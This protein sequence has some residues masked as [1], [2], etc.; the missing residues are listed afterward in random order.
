MKSRILTLITAV[1]VMLSSAVPVMADSAENTKTFYSPKVTFNNNRK[2]YSFMERFPNDY[3]MKLSDTEKASGKYSLHA[4]TYRSGTDGGDTEQY[5]G[6][7]ADANYSM[8]SNMKKNTEYTFSVK[9]KLGESGKINS[10]RVYQTGQ[11]NALSEPYY[12]IKDMDNTPV[13]ESDPDG[14]RIYTKT[15]N[16]SVCDGGYFH[17]CLGSAENVY[18]DD[19]Y[20]KNNTDNE[21]LL[22]Y[23][24]EDCSVVD[25]YDP[26]AIEV[27]TPDYG[28][29]TI[30]W[31][32]PMNKNVG[33]KK[34]SKITT[35]GTETSGI[36]N[37]SLYDVSGEDDPEN[38]DL[39]DITPI[40][41]LDTGAADDTYAGVNT[42]PNKMSEC[43]LTGL[44]SDTEYK[45]RLVITTDKTDENAK[46][47]ENVS[48]TFIE[49]KTLKIPEGWKPA[50]ETLPNFHH[51]QTVGFLNNET[52]PSIAVAFYNPKSSNIKNITLERIDGDDITE[53]SG[54][55]FTKGNN[56]VNYCEING[57][58]KG[59][60]Y[61][62][63]LNCEFS[64]GTKRS[65]AF[66]G[67]A[68]TMADRAAKVNEWVTYWSNGSYENM[69]GIMRLDTTEKHSG[70]S[71]L[72]YTTSVSGASSNRYIYVANN[73]ITFKADTSYVLKFWAKGNNVSYVRFYP[74]WDN[75]N[76]LIQVNSIPDEWTY[77]ELKYNNLSNKSSQFLIITDGKVEDLWLD[78]IEIIEVGNEQAGNILSGGDFEVSDSVTLPAV[79]DVKYEAMSGKVKLTW[80]NALQ[81]LTD[82]V[83]VYERSET[84]QHLKG[85]CK[86]SEAIVYDLE[87][88]TEQ[89]LVLVPVNAYGEDGE[90][91]EIVVKPTAPA[92]SVN[93]VEF[94]KGDTKI[95]SLESGTI[96][97]KVS[98]KNKSMGDDFKLTLIAALYDGNR[99][100]ASS[101]SENVVIQKPDSEPAQEFSVDI[102]VPD[103][104]KQYKLKLFMWDNVENKTIL[105]SSKTIDNQ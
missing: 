26:S 85:I 54:L 99:M 49:G 1:G 31:R 22:D 57:L 35:D 62:F 20:L 6:N 86:S 79:T 51:I 56:D 41:S 52:D 19:I 96:T 77:Y 83:K 84:E 80:K 28:K 94:Y 25:M 69:P 89:T 11:P 33:W 32:N 87:N 44:E 58:T 67:I 30:S 42:E 66:T 4:D 39:T 29:M 38:A 59:G 81:S 10:M 72:Y 17:F 13:D 103:D 53:V 36:L 98:A 73:G 23:G 71:S 63:K 12:F 16:T 34:T 2:I 61:S 8:P 91:T 48:D 104:D 100:V 97:A 64:D 76:K 46:V 90:E 14:W 78:D 101:V 55:E 102:D 15:F 40:F 105:K 88:D 68:G 7:T 9:L 70:D 65:V 60:E 43:H 50:V 45:F 74:G 21:V 92:Y 95:T 5:F 47:T 3:Y 93:D 37:V 27:I 75:S 18:I 82:Y 24:F